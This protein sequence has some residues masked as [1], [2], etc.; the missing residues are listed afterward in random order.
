MCLPN[1]KAQ[2]LHACFNTVNGGA[3]PVTQCGPFF[4]PLVNCSTGIYDSAVW[5]E[6]IS[7]NHN[8]NGPWGLTFLSAK[9]G[10]LATSNNSYSLTVDGSY[11]IC[12]YIYNR[13]THQVDS[14]CQCVAIVY[15][16]PNPDFSATDTFNCGTLTTTF[17]PNISQGSAP[18]GPLTW[19]WGDNTTTTTVSASPVTHTY[20]CK[21]SIPPCYTVSLS[22]TDA[23]GC[24]KVI[25]KPCYIKVACPPS[26]ALNVTG[27]NSC[28]VP[29]TVS[30]QATGS[31]LTSTGLYSFWFPPVSSPPAAPSIGPSSN[32]STNYTFN[33]YGCKKVIVELKDSLTGCKAIDSVNQAIC[34][35]NVVVDSLHASLHSVCCGSPVQITLAAH[36][37]PSFAG[38]N[39]NIG[40]TLIATP[41][42]GG[43]SIPL[44]GVSNAATNY[45]SFPCSISATTVYNI[46]FQNGQVGNSC[47]TCVA[48]YSGCIPITIYASPLAKIYQSVVDTV[49]CSTNHPFCFKAQQNNSNNGAIFQWWKGNMNGA[50]IGTGTAFCASFSG[51]GRFK[52][53]LKVCQSAANGGCCA[54][55][56][57][58][59]SQI[60]QS[61]NFTV[62]QAAVSCDSNCVTIHVDSTLVDAFYHRSDSAYIYIFGDGT[63]N[64][65]SPSPIMHHCYHSTVDTCFTIKVVH[66]THSMG[67]VYCA[68]TLTLKKAVTVGHKIN[69][70]FVVTPPQQCLVNGSAC[71]KLIPTT[72]HLPSINSNSK[73]GKGCHWFFT[74]P[75]T[76]K[77]DGDLFSCDTAFVCISDLGVFNANFSTINN[78]C[79]DTTRISN[80]VIVKGILGTFKD[81]TLCNQS[82]TANNFCVKFS[83]SYTIFPTNIEALDST[84]I[85]VIVNTP[86]C[87]PS[88]T[89]YHLKAKDHLHV[90]SLTHCFCKA[91]NYQVIMIFKNDSL[92][93]P[94]DTVTKTIS[95]TNYLA[96][97]NFNPIVTDSEQCS[98]YNWCFTAEYSTPGRPFLYNIK[99]DFGDS[100]FLSGNANNDTTLI[101]PCHTYLHCGIHHVKLIISGGT[102]SDTAYQTIIIHDIYPKITASPLTVNCGNCVVFNNATNYCMSNGDYTV[103][104]FG[105][106]MSDTLYG[107]WT[108]D[109]FCYNSP[110]TS[111]CNYFIKD[112]YGCS[113]SGNI[114]VNSINGIT[115]CIAV[116]SDTSICV[117]ATVNLSDCSTGVI[118]TRCWTLSNTGCNPSGICASSNNQFSQTFNTAGYQFINLHLTNN[119]GCSADTCLKIHVSNPVAGFLGPDSISCPGSFDSLINITTGAYDQLTVS[120]SSA[121]L[122]FYVTFTYNRNLPNGIPA[123]VG[124]PVGFPGDYIICW[125]VSSIFGCSDSVCKPLH[126]SGPIGHLQCSNVYGCV[127]DSICCTLVTNST[128]N[129]II[130]YPDGSFDVLQHNNTGVYNF[131]HK[132]FIIGHQ[133]VQAFID[134]GIGCSYP[135][136]DTVHIDGPIANFSWTPFIKDFCGKADVTMIDSS[137]MGLYSLDTAHYQWYIY[138][139]NH[140]LFASF[141]HHTPHVVIGTVGSYTMQLIIKSTHGCYDT[142]IKP[143]IRVHPY[144]VAKFSSIPDTLCTNGCVHFTNLSV[145]PD[146]VKSYHWYFNWN[147]LTPF[148]TARN[149]QYC[150][151][152]AGTYHILLID[153]SINSCV[154]TSSVK[155]VV[156]LT[157]LS[158]GYHII[159]D[160]ICGN[161]GTVYFQSTSLPSAGLLYKWNFGDGNS[162]TFS[163]TNA[164][165]THAYNLPN[166][167]IDTCYN[168]WLYAKNTAGCFDSISKQVCI[169][170]LPPVNISISSAQGCNP[171]STVFTDNNA[172]VGI[173]NY[174][175]NFGDGT[176]NYQSNISPNPFAKTYFNSSHTSLA[177]FIATYSIS[178]HYNCLSSVQDTFVVYPTPFA[179]TGSNDSVCPG[180]PFKLGCPPVAGVNYNWYYPSLSNTFHPSRFIAE[181]NVTL[182][183]KDSFYLAVDNQWGCRDTGKVV[184]SVR[185]LVIPN[186]GHDTIV[187]VGD[188]IHLFANGGLT[189]QWIQMS[190]HQIIS[191]QSHLTV[192]ATANETYRVVIAGN[193]NGDSVDIFLQVFPPPKITVSPSSVNIFA[194]QPY[195]IKP[196][197]VNNGTLQWTPNYNINCLNCLNPVVAPD[198]NTVYHVTFTDEYGCVDS[199]QVTI[200]VLCDKDKS[201]YIP[202]AFEPKP[203]SKFEN[204]FF[205]VQGRG[206]KE[207]VFLRVYDRW[208]NELYN[209]EHVPV[210]KPEV[211]WNGMFKGKP[212][213]SDVYMYQLQ[214]ECADG[215]LFP[216]AGN[217][218]LIR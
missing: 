119:Y 173:V 126:V 137:I 111:S 52:V 199:T 92:G 64:I 210:N 209:A 28:T 27:G 132:Y 178:N 5:K 91:G 70:Q 204:Q 65:S 17:T 135:V 71:F 216:I 158:M 13:N 205:Y 206:I 72:P 116:F 203:T 186:A 150:Y 154:D 79:P 104:N 99:W 138:D 55:D 62:S 29:S 174:Q 149:P 59:V 69:A 101:R 106:G 153:S 40:G 167:K 166:G 47:N 192:K 148:D 24:S 218:T 9:A 1:S 189:Y 66:I 76:T 53:Y 31:S 30:V 157:N 37:S 43:T 77:P 107:N 56:S 46:C 175:I 51:Y 128:Q 105:N 45:Y 35:Q 42:G 143:F 113:K 146:P 78:G 85:I 60:H 170:K 161:N 14:F 160:T 131:C 12:L 201:V 145:N 114:S 129:P 169:S 159:N 191:T 172:N 140:N 144:P 100:T 2:N 57:F 215:T 11:K 193:C 213:M 10:S 44:G 22:V 8:C 133:L 147:N 177:K 109:T 94:P 18:Y 187:C 115:P 102:C 54:I 97:L 127:G 19:Y 93:C 171:L 20:N 208:G 194:G 176:P 48:N 23:H 117:G 165:S 4:L 108:K 63:P 89:I 74:A 39:C 151:S 197:T 139:A 3:F 123:K 61:G 182:Y 38:Q 58:V 130:K 179:C 75:N 26:V 156:V 118:T 90:P 36:M 16:F 81:S 50:P 124:I 34:I 196:D 155:V 125:K 121:P 152:S 190:T 200:I 198:V 83:P 164:N 95:V 67:G 183:L 87:V 86:S 180:V 122:N 7:S 120:M 141:Y 142:I 217:V 181:P 84:S 202:N 96:Q 88:Q 98:K 112:S 68:D 136:A 163:T 32:P 103:L 212:M 80:A 6:Q 49:R 211:G 82:G 33:A 184:L 21:N 110:I 41:Q 134:D 25:T 185:N 207:L 73:C 168:T 188:S 162:T 195:T 15:P 214:I